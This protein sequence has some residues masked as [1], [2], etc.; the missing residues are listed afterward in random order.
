LQVTVPKE[1]WKDRSGSGE[2]PQEKS[3]NLQG[4]RKN[5]IEKRGGVGGGFRMGKVATG[6]TLCGKTEGE[7]G[8][9]GD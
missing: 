1:G 8:K 9:V 6:A 2:D 3:H 4:C 5:M 7:G